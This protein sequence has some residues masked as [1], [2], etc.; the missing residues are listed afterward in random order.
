ME[1]IDRGSLFLVVVGENT[2]NAGAV[3]NASNFTHSN[4]KVRRIVEK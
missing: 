2:I 1:A 4:G 3:K